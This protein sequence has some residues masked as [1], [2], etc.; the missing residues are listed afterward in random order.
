MKQKQTV[1]SRANVKLGYGFEPLQDA[2]GVSLTLSIKRDIAN[3]AAATHFDDVNRA[4]IG[5]F[6]GQGRGD[7]RELSRL[8]RD[9]HPNR[10]LIIA[11]RR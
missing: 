7:A 6:F 5:S 2:L 11:I 4:E 3:H 1:G 8:I 10:H 9:F